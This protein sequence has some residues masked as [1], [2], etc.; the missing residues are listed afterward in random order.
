[1]GAAI[2]H[3][4]IL[5]HRAKSAAGGTMTAM[6]VLLVD[7]EPSV[8]AIVAELL[9]LDGHVVAQAENGPGALDLLAGDPAFDLVLADV[10]MPRMN[11][12]VLAREIKARYPAIRVGL[13]T[14]YGEMG[15]SD[16]RE[17]S[18]VDFVLAKPISED[19]LRR[20][21]PAST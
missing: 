21:A 16:P 19:S 10:A 18:V 7:D 17:R 4:V 1:M 13:I 12:W 8:R 14:G 15:P 6:K 2:E 3:P 11:G 9:E 20:I 5:A